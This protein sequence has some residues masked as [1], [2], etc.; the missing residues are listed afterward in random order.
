MA[1]VDNFQFVIDNRRYSRLYILEKAVLK[2]DMS[3]VQ[4]LSLKRE[5]R[6]CDEG[7]RLHENGC[8]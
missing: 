8:K 1:T 7:K 3:L 4:H 6:A 5:T 2:F